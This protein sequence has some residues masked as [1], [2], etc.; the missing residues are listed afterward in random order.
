[1]VS[2]KLR[3]IVITAIPKPRSR[4]KVPQDC[5]KHPNS[6]KTSHSEVIGQ[7]P[8]ADRDIS[9]SPRGEY[10]LARFF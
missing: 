7:F 9:G 4:E 2:E 8:V 3:T 5:R 1:M 10:R 6:P